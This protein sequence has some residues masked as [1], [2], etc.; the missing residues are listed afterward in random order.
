M[1]TF[2]KNKAGQMQVYLLFNGNQIKIL[3]Q[4]GIHTFLKI[5]TIGIPV[6]LL[7]KGQNLV[8]CC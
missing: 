2:L 8:S 4:V 5:L 6:A 1:I 3:F 7:N